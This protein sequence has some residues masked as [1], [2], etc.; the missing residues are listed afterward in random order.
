LGYEKIFISSYAKV[1][2]NPKVVKVKD[3]KALY[4]ALR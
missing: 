1:K 2:A 4:G 3:I